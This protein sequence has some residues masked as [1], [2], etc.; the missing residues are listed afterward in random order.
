MEN[1]SV[2][3]VCWLSFNCLNGP[4]SESG[5][6]AYVECYAK[7]TIEKIQ[8]GL[9]FC[10]VVITEIFKDHGYLKF[11]YKHVQKDGSSI[12]EC[13]TTDE[14]RFYPLAS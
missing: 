3:T 8:D 6:H 4:H 2:G 7:N 14:D 12:Y 11:A 5:A 9:V 10:K 13:T 1:I